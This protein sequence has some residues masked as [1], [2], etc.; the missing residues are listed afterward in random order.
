MKIAII[1]E[2]A[3]DSVRY[4]LRSALLTTRW[5]EM[6]AYTSPKK[7]TSPGRF[8]DRDGVFQLRDVDSDKCLTI[9]RH[10]SS[11]CDEGGPARPPEHPS[12]SQCRAS[13][14]IAE[15]DIHTVV[16]RLAA[17]CCPLCDGK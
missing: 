12:D 7:R 6:T 13:H 2:N 5:E 11:S 10:G 8:R 17:H 15:A 9:I 1:R 16:L 14:L 4:P 3:K